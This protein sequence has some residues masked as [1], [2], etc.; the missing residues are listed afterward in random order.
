MTGLFFFNQTRSV[1]SRERVYSQ[2][3]QAW[4]RENKS[5]IDLIE[6]CGVITNLNLKYICIQSKEKIFMRSCRKMSRLF[7]GK[8]FGKL[9]KEKK[10][11]QSIMRIIN[12][13]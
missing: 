10:N 12:T 13:F 8:T 1:C 9:R 11:L 3:G 6:Y 7:C 2:D 4:G 5:Q